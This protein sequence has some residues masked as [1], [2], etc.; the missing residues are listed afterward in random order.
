MQLDFDFVM[1]VGPARQQF[2]A[3]KNRPGRI[4]LRDR[5]LDVVLLLSMRR[6]L[7][8]VDDD[9]IATVRADESITD[10]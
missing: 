7:P 10:L 4:S 9:G 3:D 6:N 5:N 2:R 1:S 8:A